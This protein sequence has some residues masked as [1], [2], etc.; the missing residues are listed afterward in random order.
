[1]G[2]L[3]LGMCEGWVYVGGWAGVCVGGWGIG[4]WV[5]V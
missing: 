4:L 1:M 5:W 3:N 2:V